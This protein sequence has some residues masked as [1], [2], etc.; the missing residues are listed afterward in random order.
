MIGSETETG[1]REGIERVR[2]EEAMQQEGVGERGKRMSS[3]IDNEN[4]FSLKRHSG[5]TTESKFINATNCCLL[6]HLCVK[7]SKW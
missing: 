7:D 5:I 4:P 3:L 6:I 2:R 1:R